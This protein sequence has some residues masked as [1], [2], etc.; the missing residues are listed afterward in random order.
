MHRNS[1]RYSHECDLPLF[2]ADDVDNVIWQWL[3]NKLTDPDQLERG[4]WEIHEEQEELNT[5]VRNR[6]AVIED[7]LTQHRTQLER[8]VDLYVSGGFPREVLVER[9]ARLEKLIADLEGQKAEFMDH[10]ASQFL[11]VEQ[12]QNAKDLAEQLATRIDT[13]DQDFGLKRQLVEVLDL[14]ATLAL[15]DNQKVVYVSCY[16][17]DGQIFVHRS[18]EQTEKSG[19]SVAGPSRL[20]P[21]LL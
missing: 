9:K 14:R 19:K 3:K 7:L 4:L 6:L 16:L 13:I 18:S 17:G 20:G 12:I 8:L 21:R 10:L 5:P 2:P 15:E 11:T 1:T